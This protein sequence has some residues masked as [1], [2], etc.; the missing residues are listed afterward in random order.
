MSDIHGHCD[1][2]FSSV[3]DLLQNRLSQGDELGAS[4]CVN[5]DGK[6]VLDLWGGHADTA[7]TK[8]WNEDTVTGVWSV[9]KV[10]TSL[11]A[12]ILIDRGLL[13][14]K[15]KVSKYWP[16][17]GVNGKENI[18]VSHILSHS[19]GVSAWE[20]PVTKEDI[21]DVKKSTEK[22]AQQSPWW[23]PGEHSG[24]HLSNQGHMIG[25]LVRRIS[26]KSLTQ[27]IADEIANP[28]NADFHLGLPEE[29]WHRA[30]ENTPPPHL[31]L[32]GIDP[33]SVA[34]K[35]LFGSP[36]PA[37]A[38]MSAGF[39][40]AEIGASNGFSNA[41]ALAR[42]GSMVVLGGTVDGRQY[43]SPRTIDGMVE[44]QIRG[45][46]LVLG[47]QMRFGLGVGLPVS[48]TVPFIPEGRICFW[49]GWGGSM[50][51]MD[52]DRRMS[53]GYVMNKMGM[54][55]LGNENTAAYVKA[56]YEAVDAL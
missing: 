30:A 48:Q 45:L 14:P 15:E 26:G 39:R 13:D 25:E 55:T 6:N 54:G 56:I 11:A 36:L 34:G 8:P 29:H 5:I 21:Y 33:Q 53:I 31:P 28:L 38:V 42:I 32:D 20:S 9:S 1:P 46:D 23:T 19:S 49:G 17:F 41:R 22:L 27:F 2:A 37:D 50:I 16:E 4:L 40:K 3:R 18:L 43:L 24:Y 10:I 35:S 47:M 12:Q 7:R 44:E 52:L 51:I